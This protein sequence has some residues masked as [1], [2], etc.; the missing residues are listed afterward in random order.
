MGYWGENEGK[1]TNREKI[2]GNVNLLFLLL[3]RLG[4]ST[5]LVVLAVAISVGSVFVF[6]VQE[7][8]FI[9]WSYEKN[10]E[11]TQRKE[12]QQRSSFIFC[13]SSSLV[14]SLTCCSC[15]S[16]CRECWCCFR[17]CCCF[18]GWCS[19]IFVLPF[20]I[21]SKCLNTQSKVFSALCIAFKLH[22]LRCA[23]LVS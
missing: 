21:A 20:S 2:H 9:M 3:L 19:F 1:K 18:C 6:D 10:E 13:P 22:F 11:K 16:H 17:F 4:W 15:C 5:W 12:Q 23:C 14:K 7:N 8:F